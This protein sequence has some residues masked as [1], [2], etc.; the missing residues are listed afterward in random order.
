MA[1]LRWYSPIVVEQMDLAF[2]NVFCKLC[3]GFD[4]NP[5]ALCNDP[6]PGLSYF[7]LEP[8]TMLI[9]P[10]MISDFLN[11][12]TDV[13]IASWTGKCDKAMVKHPFKVSTVIYSTLRHLSESRFLPSALY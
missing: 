4:N 9:K 2:A 7:D 3:N 10:T 1:C 8:F 11:S 13:E 6:S 12:K 5:E